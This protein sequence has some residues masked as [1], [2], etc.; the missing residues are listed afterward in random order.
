VSNIRSRKPP[1]L[2]RSSTDTLLL[3]GIKRE[4]TETPQINA[5]KDI[6]KPLSRSNSINQCKR[7]LSQRE[8]D[9]SAMTKF[10]GLKLKKIVAVEQE[11]KDAIATLKKP[12]RSI[13]VKDY[14]DD[15]DRR[16]AAA[17]IRPHSKSHSTF[18]KA[19]PVNPCKESSA[20]ARVRSARD[21]QVTA[22]PKRSKK[23]KDEVAVTPHQ[24]SSNLYVDP[25]DS[26]SAS[27]PCIPSSAIRSV[28]IGR[29]RDLAQNSS[30]TILER[31]GY[32]V[33]EETPSRGP[34][35]HSFPLTPIGE[36]RMA[37]VGP[38]SH[39]KLHHNKQS[40]VKI[41]IP[42][43]MS[44]TW[45]NNVTLNNTRLPCESPP[46]KH[47]PETPHTAGGS[48]EAKPPYINQR[49][50]LLSFSATKDCNPRA[51]GAQRS[52]YES[53]GWDDNDMDELM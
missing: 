37:N 27:N 33:V 51:S 40:A 39:D 43:M 20:L 31:H 53:L 24:R 9:M 16:A 42:D 25:E 15:A 19:A 49:H 7:L 4:R 45:G 6:R 3:Q 11:L 26:L 21:V 14:V 38:S 50:P 23:T 52:I 34:A 48:T 35:K 18:T 41:A 36:N 5:F 13:A 28:T 44:R 30:H 29:M 12:N 32:P 8:V 22:T 47:Q 1:S 10:K 17:V 2:A 46:K